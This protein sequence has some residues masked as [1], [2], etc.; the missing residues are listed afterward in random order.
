M[1]IVEINTEMAKKCNPT[2]CVIRKTAP[3]IIIP[4]MAL[5]TAMKECAMHDHIP[6]NLKTNKQA[7]QI[8]SCA[9]YPDGA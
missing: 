9:A 4:D 3:M 8:Q 1:L 2:F 7:M 5:V 6:Y